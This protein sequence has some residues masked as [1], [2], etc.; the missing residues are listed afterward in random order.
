MHLPERWVENKGGRHISTHSRI[1]QKSTPH[2]LTRTFDLVKCDCSLDE[3]TSARS[4]AQIC[5]HFEFLDIN[6][7]EFGVNEEFCNRL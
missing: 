6:C 3:V 2:L 4:I 1:A 5:C 7:F